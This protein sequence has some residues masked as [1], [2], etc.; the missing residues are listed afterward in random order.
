MCCLL[1]EELTPCYAKL[2][3]ASDLTITGVR[4]GFYKKVWKVRNAKLDGE[5]MQIVKR[6][7]KDTVV[8]CRGVWGFSPRKFLDSGAQTVHSNA[9]LGHFTPIPIPPPLRKNF[10]SDLHWSQE[11]SWELEKSL[12]SDL[13]LK[14]LSPA[15]IIQS[16]TSKFDFFFSFFKP[17]L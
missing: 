1:Q 8:S 16:F 10:S 11:W 9:F 4:M 6:I 14:I 12:K 3:G 17:G 2:S 7:Q 13:S 15:I 5:W